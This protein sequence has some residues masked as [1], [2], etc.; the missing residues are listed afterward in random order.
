MSPSAVPAGG[1]RSLYWTWPFLSFHFHYAAA[2]RAIR[3][4]A[5]RASRA[6]NGRAM[7]SKHHVKNWQAV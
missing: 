7:V 2:G 6:T 4:A 5:R 3:L 1:G